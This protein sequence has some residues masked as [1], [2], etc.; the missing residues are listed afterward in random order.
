[1]AEQ[2]TVS[3]SDIVENIARRSRLV[4]HLLLRWV[5]A[6]VDFIVLALLFLAP[7]Y[8]LGNDLYR[9]T[10]AIWLGAAILYFPIGE[11][12]WGRT[13]G[14]L[15]TGTIV[16]DATGH[17]PGLLKASLRTLLRLIEVNPLLAGGIPAA[18]AV[19]L[20]S[21]RQRLGDMVVRTYVVRIKKLARAELS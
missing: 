4:P 2:V 15:V 14:K 11:G 16:V 5:G 18:L 21:K 19:A 9:A 8:V 7:D 3:L 17:A 20:S 13:I 6:W 12:V 10:L 1:M